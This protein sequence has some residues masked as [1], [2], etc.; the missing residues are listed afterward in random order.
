MIL[1]FGLNE[2]YFQKSSDICKNSALTKPS[3][4]LQ[5]L[6]SVQGVQEAIGT[7]QA[8]EQPPLPPYPN[9]SD[10]SISGKQKI[11]N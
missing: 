3:V 8:E 11:W 9:F 2:W 1:I 10:L 6:E 5:L 7:S 4:V